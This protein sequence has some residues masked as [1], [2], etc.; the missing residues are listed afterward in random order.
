M[1]L[2]ALWVMSLIGVSGCVVPQTRYEEA[3]SALRV[4]VEAHRRTLARLYEVESKLA[5]L[6]VELDQ[7]EARLEKDSALLAQSE[8]D[9]K[10][11]DKERQDASELVDQLRGELGRVGD[12]LRLFAEERT[13]LSDALDSTEARV[14]RLIEAERQASQ[15]ALVMRDLALLLAEP[16][17][18]GDLELSVDSGRPAVRVSSSKLFV[19]GSDALHPESQKLLSALVKAARLHQGSRIS[20]TERN[21]PAASQKDG[22]L[23]LKRI[24]DALGTRGLESDRISIDVPPERKTDA[25]APASKSESTPAKPAQIEFAFGA[26]SE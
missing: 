10:L 20:L 19:D 25:D 26:A 17:S 23:R 11:V 6:R 7:R 22:A 8:L 2:R 4:E 13:Q 15:A 1:K 18:V 9:T 16:V 21:S 5:A 24:A 3:R 14:E 12:H